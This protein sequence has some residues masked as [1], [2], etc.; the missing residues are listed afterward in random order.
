MTVH[1]DMVNGHGICHGGYL[2]L[3]ADSACNVATVVERSCAAAAA[4]TT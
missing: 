1:A 4:C 2:F 3:L